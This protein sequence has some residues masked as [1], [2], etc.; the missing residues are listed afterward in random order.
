[1]QATAQ[2]VK[3]LSILVATNTVLV[4]INIFYNSGKTI[5]YKNIMSNKYNAYEVGKVTFVNY[6]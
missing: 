5:V 1:M 6:S 2:T 4:I 3:L